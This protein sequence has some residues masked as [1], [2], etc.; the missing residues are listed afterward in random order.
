MMLCAVLAVG[1]VA[2]KKPLTTTTPL[3][4][5][6]RKEAIRST[7]VAVKVRRLMFRWGTKPILLGLALGPRRC[8]VVCL[9]FH[10]VELQLLWAGCAACY[11]G[12]SNYVEVFVELGAGGLLIEERYLASD[13]SND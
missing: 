10:K 11:L 7:G 2:A 9:A 5:R 3:S 4:N 13:G 8:C 6:K 1:L 12:Q